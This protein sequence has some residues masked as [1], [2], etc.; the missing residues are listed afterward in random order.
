MDPRE[1]RKIADENTLRKALQ[2]ARPTA[3]PKRDPDQDALDRCHRQVTEALG[4]SDSYVTEVTTHTLNSPYSNAQVADRQPGIDVGIYGWRLE[5]AQRE[6]AA[7]RA[8]G[9]EVE[10]EE[11]TAPV[12]TRHSG[13][14]GPGCNGTGSST[15]AG[16]YRYDHKIIL[17][18]T[19]PE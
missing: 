9:F 5:V 17:R 1:A 16:G 2:Q 19:A 14:W 10:V 11:R 15:S 18:I 3:S 6:A 13:S 8:N 4:A 12:W 7:L